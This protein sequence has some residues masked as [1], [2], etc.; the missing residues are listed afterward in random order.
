M[1]TFRKHSHPLPLRRET[2]ELLARIAVIA[3]VVAWAISMA[4]ALV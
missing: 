3:I 1:D 4:E 2:I